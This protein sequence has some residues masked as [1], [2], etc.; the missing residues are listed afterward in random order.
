MISR[1]ILCVMMS[2]VGLN[3]LLP[4]TVEP[5]KP[6]TPAQLQAKG[7]QKSVSKVCAGKKKSMTVK[8]LCKQWEA[9]A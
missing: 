6:L 1:I 2:G 9:N 5:L 7:K 3:G 4:A 8:K